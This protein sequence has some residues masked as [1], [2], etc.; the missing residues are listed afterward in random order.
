MKAPRVA[1]SGEIRSRPDLQAA[2]RLLALSAILHTPSVALAQAGTFPGM[3]PGRVGGVTAEVEHRRVEGDDDSLPERARRTHRH[4][5]A[6]GRRMVIRGPGA[7]ARPIRA[8]VPTHRA[9]W[10]E[11]ERVQWR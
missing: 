6:G 1:R 7:C 10:L 5:S 3:E 9:G 8:I 4:R 2:F 11:I